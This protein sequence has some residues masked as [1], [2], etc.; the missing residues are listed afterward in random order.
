[1][2]LKRLEALHFILRGFDRWDALSMTA[3]NKKTD[4]AYI[5]FIYSIFSRLYSDIIVIRSFK[6]R[7]QR[8][9]VSYSHFIKPSTVAGRMFSLVLFEVVC[10]SSSILK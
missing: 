4:H 9:Y 6:E 3:N 10:A 5:L 8:F 1:M 7:R 2:E